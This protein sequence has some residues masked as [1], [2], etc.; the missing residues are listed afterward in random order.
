[1]STLRRKKM[2]LKTNLSGIKVKVFSVVNLVLFSTVIISKFKKCD[3][4]IES[5][6]KLFGARLTTKNIYFLSL[7]NLISYLL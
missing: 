2:N 6:M 5:Y 7:P 1:M 4:Y 3:D